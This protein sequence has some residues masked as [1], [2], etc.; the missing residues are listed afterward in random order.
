MSKKQSLFLSAS[1]STTTMLDP[2]VPRQNTTMP[3]AD[4]ALRTVC[5]QLQDISA[6][7]HSFRGYQWANEHLDKTGSA[8]GGGAISSQ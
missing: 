7:S 8:F 3:K 6:P 2:M 4:V 1:I 5:Q